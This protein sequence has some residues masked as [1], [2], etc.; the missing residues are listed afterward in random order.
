MHACAFRVSAHT[1]AST[2]YGASRP[3]AHSQTGT[4]TEL[5]AAAS[6]YTC[7]RFLLPAF[8]VACVSCCLRVV[9][10]PTSMPVGM[11]ARRPQRPARVIIYIYIKS[12]LA[13]VL[14]VASGPRRSFKLAW[15]QPSTN[16]RMVAPGAA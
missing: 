6:G 16:P 3:L 5:G 13:A 14:C 4:A 7:L 10:M 12:Y 2:L 11:R 8:L 1:R 15:L 9:Y